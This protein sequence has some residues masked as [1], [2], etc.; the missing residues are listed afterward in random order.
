MRLERPNSIARSATLAAYS[1]EGRSR[2]GSPAPTGPPGARIN[3]SVNGDVTIEVPQ[4]KS[5]LRKTSE[6]KGFL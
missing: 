3:D 1:D 5:S 6:T 2:R 4:R